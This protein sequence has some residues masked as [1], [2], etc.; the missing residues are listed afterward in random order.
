MSNYEQTKAVTVTVSVP[1][2]CGK[3]TA[4]AIA[5]SS[6]VAVRVVPFKMNRT[7]G[8]QLGKRGLQQTLAAIT[9]AKKKSKRR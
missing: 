6:G 2:I 4:A 5:S 9:S 7:F 1:V 8:D 3:E